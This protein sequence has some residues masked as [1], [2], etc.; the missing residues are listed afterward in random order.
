MEI[1][2]ASMTEMSDAIRMMSG[3]ESP[4]ARAASTWVSAWD[5]Q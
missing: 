4:Q 5:A 2:Q 3:T 1:L